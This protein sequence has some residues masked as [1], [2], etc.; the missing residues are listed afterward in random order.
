MNFLTEYIYYI[1]AFSLIFIG[2][3]II[4]VK[5]NLIKIII[6]FNILDTG[7]YLFLIAIGYISGGTAPVFSKSG[8]NMENMVDPVPQ[9]L[10][11]TAIV[12]E[13]AVVALALSLAIKLFSHFKTLDLRRIREQKW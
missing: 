3:Y 4:L 12:I 11:L 1:G 10:V 7:I 2:L 6:G 5:R 8:V 13:V 9:A